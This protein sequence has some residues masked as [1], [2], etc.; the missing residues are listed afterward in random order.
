MKNKFIYVLLLLGIN[1]ISQAKIPNNSYYKDES[2][3]ELNLIVDS[4]NFKFQENNYNSKFLSKPQALAHYLHIDNASNEDLINDLKSNLSFDELV[5]KYNIINFEKNLLVVK[6]KKK[7]SEYYNSKSV[8]VIE[9]KSYW[10]QDI[11][12][13]DTL[14]DL[15][16]N[17]KG[18]WLF[19][20]NTLYSGK[21]IYLDAFYFLEDFKQIEIPIAYCKMIHYSDQIIGT[22]SQVIFENAKEKHIRLP[23]NFETYSLK[24][25][26]KLLYKLRNSYVVS[27]CGYDRSSMEH[28]LNINKVSAELNKWDV[29][30]R[31]S[32]NIIN[33]RSLYSKDNVFVKNM[34]LFNLDILS[35]F[36]GVNFRFMNPNLNHFE[37]DYSTIGR[38][39]SVLK[40][41]QAFRDKM[42]E[43]IEDKNLDLNNRI[44]IYFL[45]KTYNNCIDDEGE[46]NMN[47][48]LINNS[49]KTLP[50]FI[51]TRIKDEN[52]IV[53]D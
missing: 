6:G 33:N 43:I 34:E 7:V 46:K 15:D 28:L 20:I 2:I 38:E 19:N 42:I 50:E 45:F 29:Y 49:L 1:C 8:D 26:E 23:R 48:V 12:F 36:I 4:L 13:S 21:K 44:I 39:I 18:K 40:N 5:A 41:K 24:K 22:E 11:M 51:A 25:K 53:V 27:E 32:M 17:I 37:A 31:S 3:T 35:L 10:Q 47:E 16:K 30:I 52:V 9:Y 14:T